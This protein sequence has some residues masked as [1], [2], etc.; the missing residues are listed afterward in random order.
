MEREGGERETEESSESCIQA[1]IEWDF[2]E[3]Q[4]MAIK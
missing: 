2:Q 4:E 1:R 3:R